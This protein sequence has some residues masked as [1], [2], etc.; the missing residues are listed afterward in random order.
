MYFIKLTLS[1]LKMTNGDSQVNLLNLSKNDLRK[2]LTQIESEKGKASLEAQ[3]IRDA[4][5]VAEQRRKERLPQRRFGFNVQKVKQAQQ[6]TLQRRQQAGQFI[7]E[8]QT[9]LTD[10]ERQ[11]NEFEAQ[12]QLVRDVLK[13]KKTAESTDPRAI[14]GLKG[15]RQKRFFNFFQDRKLAL[16]QKAEISR[17]ISS[18]ILEKKDGDIIFT[19]KGIQAVRSG[20]FKS[21]F[22]DKP[23]IITITT[24]SPET[25][26]ITVTD[27]ER[28]V[29]KSRKLAEGGQKALSSLDKNVSKFTTKKVIPAD[30]SGRVA[31]IISSTRFI[32]RTPVGV[33]G[34]KSPVFEFAGGVAKGA[35]DEVREK[36]VTLGLTAGIGAGVGFG[37]RT[38]GAGIVR[39]G[40]IVGGVRGASVARKIT[41]AIGLGAAGAG[42]AVIGV[43]VYK[44]IQV[45]GG[46]AFGAGEVIGRTGVEVAAFGA[47]AKAGTRLG[48]IT[49]GRFRTLGGT[50]IDDPAL[51]DPLE[52]AGVKTFPEITRGETAQQLKARFLE[53]KLP[54]E[55]GKAPR[56]FTA[57]DLPAREIVLEAPI[58]QPRGKTIK[59]EFAGQFGADVISP[60]FLR[61]QSTSGEAGVSGIRKFF[62]SFDIAGAE[63][64]V[65]RSTVT[66][67]K[68][69]KS[70]GKVG[71][72]SRSELGK[73]LGGRKGQTFEDIKAQV[74]ELPKG[75]AVIPFIKT[76]RE[77]IIVKG[78]KF[79]ITGKE[80]FV[81]VGG[82]RVPIIER[83]AI[84]EGKALPNIVP[85]SVSRSAEVDIIASSSAGG[86][87]RT[88]KPISSEISLTSSISPKSSQSLTSSISEKSL[89]SSIS[90]N[91]KKSSAKTS[92]SSRSF[93]SFSSATS[94]LSSSVTSSI[95]SRTSTSSKTG[96]SI[97]SSITTGIPKKT[98][99]IFPFTIKGKRKRKKGEKETRFSD[100]LAIVP[101][102]TARIADIKVKIPKG[103][104]KGVA[105]KSVTGLGIRGIPII[106]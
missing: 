29:S 28:K 67:I 20:E 104:L 54:S 42:A 65:L 7:Q 26:S 22:I 48:E 25:T 52:R 83:V 97:T 78:T 55:T 71:Q 27:F 105:G 85:K 76:E 89:R 34:V 9:A 98:T 102:I 17:F 64:T 32:V 41:T 62:A 90:S 59:S 35:I 91:V 3:R 88:P 96:S 103:Q 6:E 15:S 73:L 81:K 69:P 38:V 74:P 66:D 61:L 92:R 82:V 13:A 106:R 5:K 2:L 95:S 49:V 58:G 94:S 36:P 101:D 75:S 24:E 31:T 72:T 14:F 43:E 87:R 77:L 21:R 23:E 11:Q 86:I 50:R 44:D 33:V 10:I 80:F 45:R 18:G 93:T 19:E 16:Q 63:P 60:N 40:T 56:A 39:G 37:L 12:K 8:G 84:A 57:T 99:R 30:F 100:D 70:V 68:I 79:R 47:G 1:I 51:F 4:I 46:G 53:P